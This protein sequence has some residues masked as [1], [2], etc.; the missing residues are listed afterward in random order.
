MISIAAEATSGRTW[1]ADV[2]ATARPER[3]NNNEER[4]IAVQK[5]SMY[6]Q[7]GVKLSAE[8]YPEHREG[9]RRVDIDIEGG[10]TVVA[11]PEQQD[12]VDGNIATAAHPEG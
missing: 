10:I 9:R 7:H 3:T 11:H 6:T 12:G 4:Y 5:S 8:K 2:A 1:I